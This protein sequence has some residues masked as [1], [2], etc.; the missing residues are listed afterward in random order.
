MYNMRPASLLRPYVRQYCAAVKSCQHKFQLSKP[1][2]NEKFLLDEKN[3]DSIDLNIKLRKGVGDIHLVHDIKAKQSRSNQSDNAMLSHKLQEEIIK[4]P[5]D[6]HPEVRNYGNEPKVVAV[7]NEK[8]EFQH[9]P[10]EFSEIGRRLNLLRTE[11]L[12]N[13]AGHKTFFLMS[14]LAELV[15]NNN[16]LVKALQFVIFKFF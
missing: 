12:G 9:E 10:L 4:I 7:F 11:H 13:F 3:I 14:D 5:N 1:I 15:S 8:P 6:T 2:L 16:I